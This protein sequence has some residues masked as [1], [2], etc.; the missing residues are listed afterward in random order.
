MKFLGRNG[1]EEIF[2]KHQIFD[3]GC[4]DHY[5][6]RAGQTLNAANVEEAFDF[7]VYASDSLNVALLVHRTGYR[8]ILAQR[9]VGQSRNQ[10]IHFGRTCAVSI[11][12]GIR[13]FETDARSKRQR[14]ILCEVATDKS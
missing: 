6:L 9:Q 14:L 5:A 10:G 2:T 3:V 11:Y 1:F 4:G 7:F 13:L 8:D 12:T